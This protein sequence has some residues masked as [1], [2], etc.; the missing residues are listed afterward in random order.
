MTLP[1]PDPQILSTPSNRPA[2]QPIHPE[3]LHRKCDPTVLNFNTTLDLPD[4]EACFGQARAETT[5][6]FGVAMRQPGYN[7]FVFGPEGSGRHA[8]VRRLLNKAAAQ[9]PRPED[10]CYVYNFSD[11]HRPR[12]LRLP[13]GMGIQLKR[14]MDGFIAELGPAIQSSLESEQ[15][16]VH[17]EALH[18]EL[19][20]RQEEALS[21][22]GDES[23]RQGVLLIRTPKG[24]V[25]L[26]SK[27]SQGEENMNAEEFDALPPQ[28][29]ERLRELINEYGERLQKLLKEFPRWHR[30]LQ[31]G[32]NQATR[33]VIELAV[34]HLIEELKST[35]AGLPAV[36]EFLDQVERDLAASG[37]SLHQ[38][39]LEEG[40]TFKLSVAGQLSVQRYEVNLL[41]DNAATATAPLIEAD[42]PNYP[43]LVGRVEQ[44]VH[45]G[46]LETNFTLIKAGALHRANGGYLVLDAAKL[47]SHPYS[48]DGLKRV[49]HSRQLRIE[50]L[51]EMFGLTSTLSLE[52]EP[53]PLQVKVVLVGERRLYYLLKQLDPEFDSFFKV[54]VDFEDE[55]DRSAASEAQYGRLIASLARQGGL[56][57]FAN[58]AVGRLI[59][60][61]ARLAEDAHKLSTNLRRLSDLL[62]ESEYFA[63]QAGRQAVSKA[64]VDDALAAQQERTRRPHRQICEAIL[65]DTLLISTSGSRTGQVNGLAV[66][67]LAGHAFAHPVRITAT[68]RLGEG[69]VLDIERETE[70]GGRLHSKGVLILSSLLAAK[71]APSI[72]LSLAASLVFEQSYG[73]VEGD[74]ASLAELCALLSALAELPLQQNLAVTGSVDQHGTVQPIGGVNEK[75]EGFFEI[76]K[77]RGLNGSHGVLIPSANLKHL[78]LCEEV[79]S[80]VAA[81][82]FH[83]YAVER[84]DQALE[85]LTGTAAGQPDPDGH[86]P[87]GSVNHK[88]TQRL[89]AFSISRQAFAHAPKREKP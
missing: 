30:E 26:P 22:L 81:G 36:L 89:Q 78:M 44:F 47:L 57:P 16:R 6:R 60:H 8:M 49:L 74:S 43:N 59:E 67:D 50:S 85:L 37:G 4:P 21:S 11:P 58:S 24:L 33:E 23:S 77:Q 68:V 55:V 82:Q 35:Y 42:N 84:V 19:K 56:L 2:L 53:I 86:Y 65:R 76:C 51:G 27:G 79:V 14:D 41:V 63:G 28:E 88:V 3:Q 1:K 18:E 73:P 12:M 62:E 46:A 54:A 40:G 75:I 69:E 31:V 15:F 5:I 83:V 20:Q 38:Q 17:I 70:L 64:D 66:M 87:D 80:A 48:W 32:I 13:P 39:E 72:P 52:P 71:Y 45:M 10:S 9:L 34:G 7:L 29:R 61:G 25:F